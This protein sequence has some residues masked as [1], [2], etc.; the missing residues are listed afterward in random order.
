MAESNKGVGSVKNI[1]IVLSGKGGVGKTTVAAQLA[2][3]LSAQVNGARL[4]FLTG[5][6][7]YIY[8]HIYLQDPDIH[9]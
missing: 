1:V 4:S 5:M 7:V 6:I 3:T 8:I 2:Q 9:S